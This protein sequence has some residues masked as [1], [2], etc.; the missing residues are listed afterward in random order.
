MEVEG[1][2]II[3]G[4]GR[5][6]PPQ[7]RRR[8]PVASTGCI[9]GLVLGVLGVLVIAPAVLWVLGIACGAR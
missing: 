4:E 7:V 6:E 2:Q 3:G 5:G 8:G 9:V 1:S